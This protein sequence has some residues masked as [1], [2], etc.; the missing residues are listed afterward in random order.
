MC[1]LS[2]KIN[3]SDPLDRIEKSSILT[4]SPIVILPGL[5]SLA[6]LLIRTLL[7]N[8]LDPMM[9]IQLHCKNSYFNNIQSTYI[10]GKTHI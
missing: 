3:G 9:L 2:S 8:F 10:N 1:I 5:F 4:L 6:Y 7:P